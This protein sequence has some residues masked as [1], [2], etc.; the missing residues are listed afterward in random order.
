MHVFRF[1]RPFVLLGSVVL[2]ALAVAG[3]AASSGG[4]NAQLA[5]QDRI[6]GG[7]Q[8]D[9]GCFVE[10]NFCRPLPV[11]FAVDAHA[12]GSGQAAHGD[13]TF[14]APGFRDSHSQ[15]TCLAVDGH[16]AVVAGITVDSSDPS[17][18]GNL[19]V[20]F[21]V[22]RGTPSFGARD[23]ESPVYTGPA[24]PA[25]WPPGFPYVCP[26]PDTGSPELGLIRS[27]L[28]INHGDIVVQDG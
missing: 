28:P 13:F 27:F 3:Y 21:F 5:N 14:G 18:V 19:F 11:N 2:S 8:T 26:S 23:L 17:I 1:K 16:N 15:V 6:Y 9:P 7:G 4:P 24:D 22:D 12:T 25:G 20:Q 10:I